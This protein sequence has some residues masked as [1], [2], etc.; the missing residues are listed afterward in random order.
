MTG[1]AVSAKR[2]AP[3][4]PVVDLEASFAFYRRLGF[5]TRRYD[6]GGYGF[7]TL[8]GVE[9]HLG[10]VPEVV[11]PASAYLYVDDADELASRWSAAG[12]AVHPP[13]DTPWGMH[14]GAVVDPDHN[15]IRFGNP[16]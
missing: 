12:I 1:P 5:A 10:V 3:I 2:I 8:D 9:L 13:Q 6:Q 16:A 7:V 14:E 11:G 4:F 15:V